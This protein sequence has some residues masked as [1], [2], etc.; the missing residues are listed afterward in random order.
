MCRPGRHHGDFLTRI[1]RPVD[2]TN[3]G[4]DS[5]IGVVDGVE[6]HRA[7][8]A[9]GVADRCRHE[10]DHFVEQLLDPDTGL[11]GYTQYV[12]GFAAD[13]VR[14]LG[15]V[16]VRVRGRQV[17]LVQYRDDRQLF[18]ERQIEICQC[19]SFDALRGVDQQNRTLTRFEGTRDLVGEVDVAGRVDEV[20]DEFF[21]VDHP[22]Q[23]DVLGLD[24]DAAL[25]LDVHAVEVLGPHR[26]VV[27]DARELQHPVCQRRLT[28][29]DV[30][31]DAEVPD[32][33]GIGERRVG[34]AGH[35]YPLLAS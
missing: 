19:L 13:D 1:Q 31:N 14:D 24:G 3:I 6:D 29:V 16:A 23:P 9:V 32:P 25:A 35:S 21:A 30:G 18:V 4:D 26:P 33:R 34:E 15:G 10:L 20:Q 27:D 11:A 28:V 7:S 2:H 22:W 12:T 5:A 17:D 8:R